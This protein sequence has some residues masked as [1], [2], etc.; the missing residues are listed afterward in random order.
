MTAVYGQLYGL[1]SVSIGPGCQPLTVILVAPSSRDSPRV[2][3]GTANLV[4]IYNVTPGRGAASPKQE[5]MLI[6]RPHFCGII[7]RAESFDNAMTDRT[8][9]L[10]CLS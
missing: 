6:I 4:A 5:P 1:I 3:P 9:R 10:K 8:L 7:R 2:K